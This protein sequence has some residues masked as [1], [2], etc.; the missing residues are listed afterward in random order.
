MKDELLKESKTR[1]ATMDKVKVQVDELMKVR[2]AEYSV[3]ACDLT[4]RNSTPQTS[5]IRWPNW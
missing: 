4:F 3:P 1:L 2:L 5:R